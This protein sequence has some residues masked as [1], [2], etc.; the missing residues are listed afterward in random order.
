[1]RVLTHHE[2]DQVNGG[3]LPLLALAA[4][5]LLLSGCSSGNNTGGGSMQNPND[6]CDRENPPPEL[7]G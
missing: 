4:G 2:V 1:M 7:C 6:P 3:I 5:A